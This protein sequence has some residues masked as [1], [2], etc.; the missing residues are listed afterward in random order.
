VIPVARKVWQHISASMP[1]SFARRRIM[2][3]AVI[4]LCLDRRRE[5]DAE[6]N[7]INNRQQRKYPAHKGSPAGSANPVNDQFPGSA[8]TD[9]PDRS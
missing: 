4:P 2:R 9:V 5:E 3:R 6:S 1:A 7:Q 8:M